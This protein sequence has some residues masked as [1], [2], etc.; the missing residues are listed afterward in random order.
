MI[1]NQIPALTPITVL[2]ALA[3]AAAVLAVT[4]TACAQPETTPRG[5]DTRPAAWQDYAA[6]WA[7]T[8]NSA[9]ASPPANTFNTADAAMLRCR[10]LRP[11][12]DYW[13]DHNLTGGRL[14]VPRYKYSVAEHEQ[15]LTATVEW[16][17]AAHPEAGA[18]HPFLFAE[19]ICAV[20]PPVYTNVPED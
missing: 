19:T 17:R 20:P 2:L 11:G 15:C 18:G 9:D 5:T 4:L 8:A 14:P 10:N 16:F 7:D 3:I 12:A 13:L 1:R 6:C